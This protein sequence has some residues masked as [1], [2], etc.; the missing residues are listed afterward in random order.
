MGFNYNPYKHIEIVESD[1][2]WKWICHNCGGDMK[3]PPTDSLVV[4]KLDWE[5]HIRESH[6]QGKRDFTGWSNR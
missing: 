1:G 3:R 6:G 2:A 4:I 5:K